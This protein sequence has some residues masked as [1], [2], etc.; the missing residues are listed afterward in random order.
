MPKLALRA[1]ELGPSPGA[2][3]DVATVNAHN[4]SRL[5]LAPAFPGPFLPDSFWSR[6]EPTRTMT[7]EM[8]RSRQSLKVVGMVIR[9]VF[10]PVVDVKPWRDFAMVGSIDGEMQKPPVPRH[11]VFAVKPVSATVEHDAWRFISHDSIVSPCTRRSIRIHPFP[12][13]QTG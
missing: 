13:I 5:N 11:V 7:L 6:G 2:L 3:E 1:T 4:V 8:I 12:R 10:V 9:L